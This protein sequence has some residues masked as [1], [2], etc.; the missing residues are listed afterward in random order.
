MRFTVLA[1]GSRG[2]A[3]LLEA[4]GFGL[5]IDMGLGP[6]Q[7]ARRLH[8]AGVSWSRVHAVLLS[9]THGDHWNA[10][11]IS[12]LVGRRI[13]LFCHHEHARALQA[14][15]PALRE[16]D[17]QRLLRRYDDAEPFSLG[18]WQCRPL[19][20]EHDSRP[21]FGF[22]FDSPADLFAAA[23][24]LAHLSDLGTW[25]DALAEAI[26]GVDVLALEFNHDVAMQRTSGRSAMLIDR[27]L[28]DEGHLSNDQAAALLQQV[29]AGSSG[30][31]L[32]HVV[33]LHLSRDCNRPA[34][35]AI[36]AREAL[37]ACGSAAQ[38][39]TAMQDHP[40]RTIGLEPMAIARCDKV[41]GS[42]SEP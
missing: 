10:R 8:L 20:V 11:T 17:A 37:T 23:W 25:D 41:V 32:K 28:G 21:T 5:L 6:R 29:I 12:H 1:S 7:L 40:L 13:M 35:A 27:V 33:Q 9:H 42:L 38:V 34:L 39:H 3:S 2:N 15:S 26:A 18:T 14:V 24:A 31:R 36:A 22:R 16:L 19:V 30:S 4:D